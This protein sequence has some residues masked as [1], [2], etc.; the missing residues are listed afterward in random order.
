MSSRL[1]VETDESAPHIIDSTPGSPTLSQILANHG[2]PLNTRCGERG[3]CCGCEVQL[4][5]GAVVSS[6]GEKS[7]APATVRACQVRAEGNAS[8]RIP[9]RSRIDHRPWVSETFRIEIPCA[10]QPLFPSGK[11]DTAFAIDVGTT[12][13][14]VLLVD[15]AS[16]EVLSRAGAFNEQIRFGDNVVTR[17]DAVRTR[18]GA[19]EGMQSAIVRETISPLLARACERAKRGPER[20]AGGAI[21]G[22][23][24]ML[25]LLAG[26]DPSSLGVAPFSNTR[27]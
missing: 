20:L 23:T 24:T 17:I 21:A 10:H 16:G 18:P 5:K 14:A 19:L 26:V 27:N 22:N 3:L 13:V 1:I 9:A 8:I 2:F 4:L 7:T 11:R 15:I 6:T 12:T 25:H